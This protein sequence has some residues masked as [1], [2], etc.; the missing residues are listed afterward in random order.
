MTQS[1]FTYVM[2]MEKLFSVHSLANFRLKM[3]HEM[4]VGGILVVNTYCI[5][6]SIQSNERE[7]KSSYPAF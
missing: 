1:K 4:L 7:N 3:S 6:E 2:L 5:Q